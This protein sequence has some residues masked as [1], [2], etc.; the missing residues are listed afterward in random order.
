MARPSPAARV[1]REPPTFLPVEVRRVQPLTPHLLRVTFTGADV[2]RLVPKLP[3]ASIRVLLPSGGGAEL[4]M[5]TWHGN[6][7]LLPDGSRPIIR[8]YTPRHIDPQSAELEVDIVIHPEGV[9][10][11]WALG[12]EPGHTAAISGPG[13]GYVIDPEAPR[14]VLAGDETA[15]PAISQLLEELPKGPP[16]QV[17]IE[18]A[19]PDARLPLPDH[20][21]TTVHWVDLPA[22]AAPGEALV[23]AVTTAQP[24]RQDRVWVAGEAAAVQRIRKHL[25]DELGFSRSQAVVRGYWKHGRAGGADDRD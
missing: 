24:D 6:E 7:F 9:A 8:T 4:V 3:A 11:A 12:A 1:R 21:G 15:I 2:D 5:P 14:F 16:A 25:F 23:A 20:P 22:G 17:T 18:V 10:S 13:R 19:R